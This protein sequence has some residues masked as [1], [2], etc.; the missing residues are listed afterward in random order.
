MTLG[1]LLDEIREQYLKQFRHRIAEAKRAG[2]AV[3]AEA[4]YRNAHGALVR[5]GTL[6]LPLR[7]DIVESL[8]SEAHKTFTV[9]STSALAFEPIDFNWNGDTVVQLGPFNWDGCHASAVGVSE[10]VDWSCLRSWFDKWFDGEDTRQTGDDGLCGVIHFLSD[11]HKNGETV[12]FEVDFGSAP[13]E[14]FEEFLD[15]LCDSGATRI[16]I[17]Q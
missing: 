13:I 4:A 14:A 7:L 15:A 9:D 6:N 12:A 5:E 16:A 2:M 10:I 11:P 8:D 17:G 1:E 3:N